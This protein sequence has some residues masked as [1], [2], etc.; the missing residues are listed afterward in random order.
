MIK[1]EEACKLAYDFYKV[2]TN[3][4]GLSKAMDLGEKWIF[5]PSYS[6]DVFGDTTITI[7]KEDG[8][9]E[10]FQLPDYK[11]FELLK[12]A[13]SLEIPN[14]FKITKEEVID[15]YTKRFGGYPAFLLMGATDEII[16]EKLL[17]SLK[18]GKELIIENKECDY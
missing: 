16:I 7:S 14:E 18:T 13:T 12:N 1:Y 17:E 9:I 10:N 2:S 3:V 15:L 8:Q 5:Y 6:E 4:N 11:N